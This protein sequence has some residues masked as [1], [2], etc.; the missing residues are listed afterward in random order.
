[1]PSA[2]WLWQFGQTTLDLL[3]SHTK[4]ISRVII[5]VFVSLYKSKYD[6]HLF[7]ALACITAS[8]T[9]AWRSGAV[10]TCLLAQ[11]FVAGLLFGHNI[12]NFIA[13]RVAARVI[14]LVQDFPTASC[15]LGLADD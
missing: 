11:E 13:H 9:L 14:I 7:I 10:R 8:F 1:M 4:Q 6:I 12:G 3:V 5:A 15:R 2:T